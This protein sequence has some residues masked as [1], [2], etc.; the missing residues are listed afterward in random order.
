MKKLKKFRNFNFLK[1]SVLTVLM[2]SCNSE[3]KFDG[4]D[5]ASL[6]TVEQAFPDL[7]GQIK[8][9]YYEG[10]EVIYEN[11]DGNYV[12]EGDII[13]DKKFVTDHVED[14][15]HNEGDD[16]NTSRSVG[17][18]RARWPN[19]TVYYSIA[20]NLPYKYRV[21]DAIRHWEANTNVKF[22]KRT[23]QRNYVYFRPG[24]G[25]SSYVGMIGGRQDIN[26]ASGCNT[27]TTIHEIGHAVGLYHEQSR[28]DRDRYLTVN[29]NNITNGMAHN[30]QTYSQR[31]R[32]GDEYTRALDFNS[33]MLYSSYAFSRNGRPTITKKNGSTYRTNRKGLS[34]GDIEGI[35]KMYPG[36]GSGSGGG[37]VK[38]VNGQYYRID[39]L[40]VY[41]YH[42]VWWYWTRS[43][44]RQVK[45]VNGRWYWV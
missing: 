6:E 40:R 18:T 7:S 33:V 17:R 23:N 24:R 28:K 21:T 5:A 45:N 4:P 31:R 11:I 9:G 8:E 19:N 39:G 27:G 20:S 43:G 13:L 29:F 3:N 10:S 25:C 35:N 14:L 37:G 44:W 42:D 41:R 16:V 15:I 1:L 30:F 22:V 12:Y 34:S 2:M 32:D 38:Y 26:L 36:S